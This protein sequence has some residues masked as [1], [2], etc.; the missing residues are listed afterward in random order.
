MLVGHENDCTTTTTIKLFVLLLLIY[1]SINIIL[2]LN[3]IRIIKDII[4]DN[5]IGQH[6]RALPLFSDLI[7]KS[8]KID[9]D[10]SNNEIKNNNAMT[11]IITPTQ[12]EKTLQLRERSSITSAGLGGWG[13]EPKC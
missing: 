3:N 9:I 7:D 5:Y 2:P 8:D 1:P 11:V 6:T 4:N 12:E 13:S 10:D